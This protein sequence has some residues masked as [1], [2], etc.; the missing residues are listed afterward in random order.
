MGQTALS[1]AY[2]FQMKGL[3]FAKGGQQHHYC[4]VAINWRPCIPTRMSLKPLAIEK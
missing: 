1:L 4:L 2:D 3:R